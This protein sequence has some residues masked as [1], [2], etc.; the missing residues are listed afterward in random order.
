MHLTGPDVILTLKVAV[1]AV[2]LLFLTSLLFL[3]R[4]NYWLHGRINV[5]FFI[6]TSAAL[7]ALEVVKGVAQ[8][9]ML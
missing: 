7:V 8:A 3:L 6:L 1:L 2:T 5:A 9:L 4:G